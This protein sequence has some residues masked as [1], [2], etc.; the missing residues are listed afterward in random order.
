VILINAGKNKYGT[1]ES[2]TVSAKDIYGTSRPSP[3]GSNT[4]IGAVESEYGFPFSIP[5]ISGWR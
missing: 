4:D 1:N 5:D 2:S 3:T